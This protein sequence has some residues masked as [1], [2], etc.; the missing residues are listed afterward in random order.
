MCERQR[1]LLC[2]DV[3]EDRREREGRWE[4]LYLVIQPSREATGTRGEKE[5]VIKEDTIHK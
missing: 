3:R 2:S 4:E 1:V 5:S